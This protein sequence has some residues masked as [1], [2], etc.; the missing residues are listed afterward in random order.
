MREANKSIHEFDL[1]GSFLRPQ[2]FAQEKF[3][4]KHRGNKD[5]EALVKNQ[6]HEGEKPAS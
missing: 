1:D 5:A 6:R 4:E 3:L 2:V